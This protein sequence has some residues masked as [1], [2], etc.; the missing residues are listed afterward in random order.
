M[1]PTLLCPS[2]TRF[3]SLGLDLQ[4]RVLPFKLLLI[5]VSFFY[6]LNLKVKHLFGLKLVF[7]PA[8]VRIPI[9]H[10]PHSQC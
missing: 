6:N 3:L 2:Q 10:G 8:K 7:I 9:T 4:K 5:A 1:N